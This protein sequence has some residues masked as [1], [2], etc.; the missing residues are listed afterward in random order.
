MK[1]KSKRPNTPLG[2]AQRKVDRIK[3]FYRHLAVYMIVNSVML[4]IKNDFR[5]FLVNDRSVEGLNF[6]EWINW[7]V[8]GSIILWG[9]GLLIHAISVFV[10]NPFL[11]KEW[12][13]RQIQ[14]YMKDE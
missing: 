1:A 6:L 5:F 11:G 8:Y 14:K 9:I 13:A 4:L 7:N 3:G 12:E 10:K 2:R